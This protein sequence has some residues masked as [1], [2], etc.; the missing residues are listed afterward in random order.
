MKII[1]DKITILTLEVKKV[2]EV[3]LVKNQKNL[4]GKKSNIPM[5][6]AILSV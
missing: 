1:V 4:N 6:S 5:H 2:V 3:L